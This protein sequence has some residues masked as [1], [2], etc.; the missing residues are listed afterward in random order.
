MLL[1]LTEINGMNVALQL[2]YSICQRGGNETEV[3][4]GGG[5]HTNVRR[6][7]GK[8]IELLQFD[9]V[10]N[11]RGRWTAAPRLCAIV[12]SCDDTD[13]ML[14]ILFMRD[15]I[16]LHSSVNIMT[17]NPVTPALSI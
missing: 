13:H 12:T 17:I 4:T 15:T 7:S 6:T 2:Y 1:V 3:G 11:V 9:F 8:N 10:M 16:S 14:C 5:P